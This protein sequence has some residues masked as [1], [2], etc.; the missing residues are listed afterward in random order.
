MARIGRCR[1]PGRG[2]KLQICTALWRAHRVISASI[3]GVILVRIIVLALITACLAAGP[4]TARGCQPHGWLKLAAE[5]L[6]AEGGD[7]D[8]DIDP[9]AG[10]FYAAMF[11]VKDSNVAINNVR[12]VFKGGRAQS[13]RREL[14]F[15]PSSPRQYIDFSQNLKEI[16]HVEFTYRI[17]Y[18]TAIGEISV[19]GKKPVV[20]TGC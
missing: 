14:V 1:P 8:L 15:G 10:G 18:G 12:I 19:W 4:A 11:E 13:P 3:D 6:T 7:V 9:N 17:L 2:S 20:S 5:P 16:D